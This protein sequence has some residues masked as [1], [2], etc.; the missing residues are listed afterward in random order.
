M[1]GA[2]QNWPAL[3]P[4]RI[5]SRSRAK[6]SATSSAYATTRRLETSLSNDSE[7]T[8]NNFYTV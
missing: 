8:R 7:N 4:L 5:L 3:N 2:V 1:Q 6:P